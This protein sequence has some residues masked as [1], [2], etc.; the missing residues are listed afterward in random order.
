MAV[1]QYPWHRYD[2][3]VDVGGGNGQFMMELLTKDARLRGVLVDQDEQVHRGK[4][5]R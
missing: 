3:I 1:E 4:E 2:V 5:V